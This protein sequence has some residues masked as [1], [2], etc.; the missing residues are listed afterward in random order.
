M[1]ELFPGFYERTEE[2][3][4][5]LWGEAT[6]VFDTNMLLN[7]YRYKEET[8]NRFFEILEQLKERIWTP[9][10]AIYEYQNN[11]LEVIGQQLKVYGGAREIFAKRG[12]VE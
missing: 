10:Q 7:I 2:E 9:H 1:K 6:F 4:A 3:L 12:R 5:M 8:R 11:R